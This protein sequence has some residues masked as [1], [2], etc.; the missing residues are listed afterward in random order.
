[1]EAT[2]EPDDGGPAGGPPRQL[3]RSFDGFGPGVGEEHRV[4]RRG[5]GRHQ[6][7]R[8]IGD[9]GQEPQ[10]VA[11]VEQLVGLGVDRGAHGR[12]RVPQDGDR[13]SAREVQ[14]F[15]PVGVPQAMTLATHPAPLEVAGE[16]G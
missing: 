10:S 4:E 12:V 5:Q 1:M 8:E 15:P 2:R 13:E 16:H 11:H 7:V 3:H 9:R 6:R 14:V